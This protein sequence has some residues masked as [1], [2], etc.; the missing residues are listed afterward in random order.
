MAPKPKYDWPR[1][2]REAADLAESGQINSVRALAQHFG[3][4]RPT[5]QSALDR[6]GIEAQRWDEFPSKARAWAD[7]QEEGPPSESDFEKEAEY[8]QKKPDA[9]TWEVLYSGPQ[10]RTEADLRE[11]YSLPVDEWIADPVTANVWQMA[12]KGI[13]QEMRYADGKKSGIQ[14]DHGN[15]NVANLYQI[16]ATFRRRVPV[17]LTP[18][19]QPVVIK[20]PKLPAKKRPSTNKVL[21]VLDWGDPQFGFRRNTHTGAFIGT[22]HDRRA[23]SVILE[24]LERQTFDVI[25]CGGD[26]LDMS[27]WSAHYTA[28]PNFF[29][30]TQPALIEA[31]YWL[32]AMVAAAGVRNP[33]CR[34]ISLEGNHHRFMQMIQKHLTAAYGLRPADQLEGPEVFSLPFFLNFEQLGIEFIPGY[35]NG[36]AEYWLNDTLRAVHGDVASSAPGA[37]ARKI[38]DQSIVTTIFHHIHR[39]ELVTKKTE[40]R[41]GHHIYTAVSAGTTCR[42]DG[43]VPGSKKTHNWQQG[44]L[45]LEYLVERPD[46]QPRMNLIGID[47]GIAVYQGE[48][49]EAPDIE[50]KMD[51]WV[52][53]ELEKIPVPDY[54]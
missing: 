9:N 36:T 29:F 1:I 2:M 40:V 15:I 19:L 27:E 46:V 5:F 28:N 22:M 13:W 50:D 53:R 20:A 31:Y 12:R 38:A 11:Y 43:S 18:V 8:K 48:M 10:L 35:E 16:K 41:D 14:I 39:R 6:M 23:L 54:N 47:E 34:F 21:R 17:A 32:A 3:I 25:L 37:T 44:V 42:I 33:D 30:T 7:Q 52:M 49:I 4:S 24:V 26:L 51:D 45:E